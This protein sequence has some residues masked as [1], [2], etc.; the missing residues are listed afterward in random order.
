MGFYFFYMVK[1]TGPESSISI[2]HKDGNS[3][4]ENNTFRNMSI[5]LHKYKT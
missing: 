2:T 5:L 4:A 1:D 3:L